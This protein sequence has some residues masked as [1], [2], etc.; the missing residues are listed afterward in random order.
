MR[1][2]LG[3]LKKPLNEH[4]AKIEEPLLQRCSPLLTCPGKG[5]GAGE[6]VRVSERGLVANLVMG[7]TAPWCFQSLCSALTFHLSGD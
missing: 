6:E 5:T 3:S 2:R 4:H 7:L 1:S